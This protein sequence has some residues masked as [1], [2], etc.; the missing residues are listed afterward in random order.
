MITDTLVGK[1]GFQCGAVEQAKSWMKVQEALN[2]VL[3][4]NEFLKSIFV[5]EK[6]LNFTEL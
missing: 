4:I 2:F 5:L 6:S 3:F 1:S